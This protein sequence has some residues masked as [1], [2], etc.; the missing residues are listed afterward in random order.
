MRY[1][2]P[3]AAAFAF[4]LLTLPAAASAQSEQPG[5][6]YEFKD[7]LM[8]GDTFSSPPPELRVRRKIPRVMLLRPRA[9]FVA[10]LLKS[11]EVL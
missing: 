10:E 5:Y 3:I 4:A 11:V 7:D 9:H 2:K 6:T 1:S 8:V